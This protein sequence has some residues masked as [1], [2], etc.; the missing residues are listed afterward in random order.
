MASIRQC[1]ACGAVMPHKQTKRI[2]VYDY[3][4]SGRVG[5]K[6]AMHDLCPVCFGKLLEILNV[7]GKKND[8]P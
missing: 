7:G 6:S 2:E 4:Y 5:T 8:K 1:D 3:D